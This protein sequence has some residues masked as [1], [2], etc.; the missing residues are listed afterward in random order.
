[1]KSFKVQLAALA[2]R[3]QIMQTAIH[4]S[5]AGHAQGQH[6]QWSWTPEYHDSTRA[7]RTELFAWHAFAFHALKLEQEWK[8]DRIKAQSIHCSLLDRLGFHLQLA[9]SDPPPS[10]GWWWVRSRTTRVGSS[11]TR[12]CCSM[13][14]CAFS[15]T[16][17]GASQCV[18]SCDTVWSSQCITLGASS[19]H[20]RCSG[21]LATFNTVTSIG[22]CHLRSKECPSAHGRQVALPSASPS[23]SSTSH[24]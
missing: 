13:I 4:I 9:S 18:S 6:R 12:S 1:M 24:A 16:G 21:T 17:M 8:I 22:S 15:Q 10:L 3:V 7:A 23:R 20:P 5:D 11:R 14:G 19:L 2:S